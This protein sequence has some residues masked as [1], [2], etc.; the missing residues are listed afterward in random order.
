MNEHCFVAPDIRVSVII[1][2]FNAEAHIAA[3]IESVLGQSYRGFELI[4]VDDGSTDGTAAIVRG[5]P[6]V[7]LIQKPNGG[8]SSARNRGLHAA[9]GHYAAFLDAD[10]RWHPDKLSVQ[11]RALDCHSDADL[12][13]VTSTID[14]EEFGQACRRSAQPDDCAWRIVVDDRYESTFIE[15]YFG[16][17]G[18]MVK[19]SALIGIG[20]FDESLR[21]GE[22]VDMYLRLL[23]DRPRVVRIE[24]PGVHVRVVANSLSS[25]DVAG[26]LG[27]IAVYARL[28]QGRPAYFADKPDVVQG[29]LSRLYFR[30]SRSLLEEGRA[31]ASIKAAARSLRLHPNRDAAFMVARAMVPRK[32]RSAMKSVLAG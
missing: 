17:S 11:V 29:T 30:L 27:L 3:A 32:L 26:F 19:T 12:S 20:G 28:I 1:P 2:A 15:P 31:L 22:D 10:D 9:N 6:S 8:V 14:A 24:Y 21:I 4:V 18:V 16:M 25:N 23:I 5:Y 13:Y 7:R